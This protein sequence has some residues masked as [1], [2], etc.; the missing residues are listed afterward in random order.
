M[1]MP[2]RSCADTRQKARAFL[3][4]ARQRSD[5]TLRQ[6]MG[7]NVAYRVRDAG[8]AFAASTRRSTSGHH[9]GTTVLNG[10]TAVTTRTMLSASAQ[11]VGRWFM[12]TPGRPDLRYWS[13]NVSAAV[14]TSISNRTDFLLGGVH[15]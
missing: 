13:C 14:A 8:I 6:V 5:P 2:H 10:I 11:R 3:T 15:P 1:T 9:C 7:V 12:A 4:E